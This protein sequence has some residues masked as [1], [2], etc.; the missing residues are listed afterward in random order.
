MSDLT[1]S[2]YPPPLPEPRA[3]TDRSG[4]LIAMAVLELGLATLCLVFLA[5]AVF[6][7]LAARSLPDGQTMNTGSMLMG[8]MVYLVVAV[9]FCGLGIG[10]LR[11]RRWA[12]T[13]GLVTSWMWLLI[14]VL[15]MV[16]MVFLLP[17]MSA[18]MTA[19]AGPGAAPSTGY[20]MMGC[21]GFFLFL[22]YLVLPLILLLFY[23]GDNVKAT[24]EAKDPSLPWTDRVPMPVLALSLLFGFSAVGSLLGLSYRVFPL[25][26]MLLTGA[27]AILAF[28]VSGALCAV[29][30]LGLYRRRPAAW[31]GAVAFW[32]VGCVNGALIFVTGG[33]GIRRMYEAME[34]PAAQL[35]QME[36]MGIYDYYSSPSTLALFAITWVGALGFI[37][38]CRRFF[39]DAPGVPAAY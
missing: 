23:R 19:A 12:R 37:V 17:K 21:V 38:W 4:A 33:A 29:L 15:V 13:I 3:Y 35:Q 39:T 18:A 9:F 14:G 32:L 26:G 5:F 16:A 10:T 2:S 28:L 24:F 36:K 6:A 31:W 27:P 7:T 30:A 11:G 20:V 8:G 1:P 34:M 25:F 22:A